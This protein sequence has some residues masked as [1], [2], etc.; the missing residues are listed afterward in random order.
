MAMCEQIVHPVEEFASL[1]W[2]KLDPEKCGWDWSFCWG[3][4]GND[5]NTVAQVHKAS[6]GRQHAARNAP[7]TWNLCVICRESEVPG[8]QVPGNGEGGGRG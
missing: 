7:R 3:G 4:Y 1:P 2:D 6:R 8:H 5:E